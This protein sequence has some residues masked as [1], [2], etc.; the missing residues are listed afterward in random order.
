MQFLFSIRI[1]ASL[2]REQ[3]ESHNAISVKRTIFRR[4]A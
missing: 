3:V 1:M 4:D 2:F